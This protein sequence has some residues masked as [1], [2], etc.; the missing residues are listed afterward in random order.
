MEIV[1]HS[2]PESLGGWFVPA[3]DLRIKETDV[4][5]TP[6]QL[7]FL[8]RVVYITPLFPSQISVVHASALC[9]ASEN[10]VLLPMLVR[11]FIFP[12]L[13]LSDFPSPSQGLPQPF[14][15][16]KPLQSALRL[17]APPAASSPPQAPTPS[18][19][20][21]LLCIFSPLFP[22]SS[23]PC[24]QHSP[25]SP[26]LLYPTCSSLS[27]VANS[28]YPSSFPSVCFPIPFPSS[29]S[30]YTQPSTVVLPHVFTPSVC[31]SFISQTLTLQP[32]PS[33]RPSLAPAPG[34]RDFSSHHFSSVSC[35]RVPLLFYD[36]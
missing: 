1:W 32:F 24:T 36:H 19:D 28:F 17:S 27:T 5:T 11:P 23:N 3:T 2:C 8:S 33:T 14:S 34:L 16:T 31:F 20:F 25:V 35:P 18:T 22:S 15:C 6:C 30:S 21:P 26:F 10:N 9:S 4:N 29:P 7:P 13:Y 12:P